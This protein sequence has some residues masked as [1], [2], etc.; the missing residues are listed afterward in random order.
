MVDRAF[1]KPTS[2]NIP[3]Q[4]DFSF[5]PVVKAFEADSI[6]ALNALLDVDFG[7]QAQS[8]TEYWVVEDVKYQVFL[9]PPPMPAVKYSALVHATKVNRV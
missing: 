4:G 2:V 3:P 6:A 9:T 1:L 8:T 7:V 5:L